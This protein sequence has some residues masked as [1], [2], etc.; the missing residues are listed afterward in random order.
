M[1]TPHTHTHA[2]AHSNQNVCGQAD[3]KLL[4]SWGFFLMLY[5]LCQ[6]LHEGVGSLKVKILTL[7]SDQFISVLKT[8]VCT[9][10]IQGCFRNPV[11]LYALWISSHCRSIV[12]IH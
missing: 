12:H 4:M 7:C 1:Y 8:F 6:L 5:F 11:P 2:H 3:M 10:E 9:V